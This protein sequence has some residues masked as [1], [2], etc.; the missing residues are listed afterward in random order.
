MS[1]E[2][3]DQNVG[4]I[5]VSERQRF[6]VAALETWMRANVEDFVGAVS[7]EQFRGG[8]SNPTFK[9]VTPTRNYVMRSKPG[10]AAKLLPLP[11]AT[12]NPTSM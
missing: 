10:P 2:N 5:P 4:T 1:T 9:L 8:Q 11:S 6:D 7:V 12:A 3:A